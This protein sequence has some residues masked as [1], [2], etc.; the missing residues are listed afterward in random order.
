MFW[1]WMFLIML[2]VVGVSVLVAKMVTPK[3]PPSDRSD[4]RKHMTALK[5][6]GA[7]PHRK[8]NRF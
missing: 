6:S 5:V 2:A 8:S 1:L 4:R 3:R 7:F